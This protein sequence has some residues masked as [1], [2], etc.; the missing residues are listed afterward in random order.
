MPETRTPPG[1]EML[2][3]RRYHEHG[4][5][6]AREELLELL[7]PLVRSIARRYA[8]RGE[9]ME[10]LVQ[11]GSIGLIKAVDRFDLERGVTLSTFAVPNIL[12]E[13]KRHFRDKGWAARVPREI[14]ELSAKVS[15]LTERYTAQYGRSPS[16]GELAEL[17]GV[18][19]E[20]I[21]DALQGSKAYSAD[22][23]DRPLE[24]GRTPLDTLG[25]REDGY[26]AA[27]RRMVL[28]HGLRALEVRE[29]QIVKLRFFDGLT[30][31]EIAER[32]DISQMHVSR[33]L[34]Q[35]L[36]RMAER[37]DEVPEQASR[38]LRAV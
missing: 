34:R 16:V 29:R 14:K 1:H 8:N 24:D 25:S 23:L 5:F 37:V 33:L 4:D 22:S 9:S 17:A 2:L 3:L 19:E 21:L 20:R 7:M 27:E 6:A 11:T 12:G 10:D 36:E 35:S 38:M 15:Q 13:I 30:Q 28:L 31:A 18:S 32:L 26:D